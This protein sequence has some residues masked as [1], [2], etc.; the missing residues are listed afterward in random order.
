M[1]YNIRLLG[2][3]I[4]LVGFIYLTL[5]GILVLRRG[6]VRIPFSR[7]KFFEGTKARVI[8]ACY[9]GAGIYSL[10]GLVSYLETIEY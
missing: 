4:L 6:A 7:K 2:P 1:S 3:V 5:E 9:L 10:Y 8:G